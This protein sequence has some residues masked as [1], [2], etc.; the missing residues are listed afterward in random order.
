MGPKSKASNV[1]RVI[2]VIVGVLFVVGALPI[3]YLASPRWEIWVVANDNKPL[4]GINVRLV[5]QN[6]STEDQSH[7]ITM[8]TDE[9]GHALFPLQYRKASFF[10][11]VFYTLV[12][13]EAGVH[14]SFGQYAYVLAFGGGY[15]TLDFTDLP[16]W[17]GSPVSLESTIV[18]KSLANSR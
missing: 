16:P 13:A 6:F 4:P 18:A 7:E 9:K 2:A 10:Q 8:T 3:R 5:Y 11:H 15:N 12:S 1:R 14:A 17:R